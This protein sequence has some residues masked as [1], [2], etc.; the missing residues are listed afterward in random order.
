MVRRLGKVVKCVFSERL[1]GDVTVIE[2]GRK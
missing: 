1:N 2:Y